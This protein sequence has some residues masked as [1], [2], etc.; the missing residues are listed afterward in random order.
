MRNWVSLGALSRVGR[1]SFAAEF[2][3]FL[4]TFI[5]HYFYITLL[6][7]GLQVANCR[8]VHDVEGNYR[9]FLFTKY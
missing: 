9:Y 4:Y 5:K 6:S 1:L 2:E 7:E 3:M 8:T